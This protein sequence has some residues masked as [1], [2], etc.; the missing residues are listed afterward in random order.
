VGFWGEGV[1]RRKEIK[2]STM[3]VT[4]RFL[5]RFLW[6]SQNEDHSQNNLAKFGYILDMKVGKERER[7]LWYSWLQTGTYH[8]NLANWNLFFFFKI[9]Q[10]LGFFFFF[11]FLFFAPRKKLVIKIINPSNLANS[12]LIILFSEMLK[13][14]K[15]IFSKSNFFVKDRNEY[16]GIFHLLKW[17]FQ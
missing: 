5:L 14:S 2:L 11:F 16:L 12:T 6:C 9:W 4:P 13:F 7:I 1:H 8:K 17:K 10:I 15:I 3:G